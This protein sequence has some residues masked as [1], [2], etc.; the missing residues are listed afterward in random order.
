MQVLQS[1]LSADYHNLL[2]YSMCMQ[3]PIIITIIHKLLI[4][5]N[6]QS[7]NFDYS[8]STTA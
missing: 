5:N 3:K 4:I 6:Y 7:L 2:A 8:H 1:W